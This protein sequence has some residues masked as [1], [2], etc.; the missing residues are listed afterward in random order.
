[1]TTLGNP[2]VL[3]IDDESIMREFVTETLVR[4][5]YNVETAANGKEGLARFRDDVYDLVLTDLKMPDINGIEV[6]RTVRQIAPATSVIVM[7]AYGTIETAVEAIR[8]GAFDYIT[9][10]LSPDV[11]E[12]TVERALDHARLAE[13][14]RYLRQEASERFSFGRMVG[15]SSPM[16]RVYQQ[17]AKVASSSTR[18]MVT[19]ES[20]TGKE[21]VARAIHEKS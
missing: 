5:G 7:T 17:V 20:G 3:V 14:V 13:E 21:L 6:V 18:V 12:I 1:M 16:N 10:P 11:I 9:K 15:D 2:R 4:A 19:G 8:L